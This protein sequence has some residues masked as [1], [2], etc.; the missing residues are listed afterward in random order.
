VVPEDVE[1]QMRAR[2]N[3]GGLLA[4]AEHA[5]PTTNSAQLKQTYVPT[6]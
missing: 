1:D 2:T 5:A 6:W 3:W 4:P